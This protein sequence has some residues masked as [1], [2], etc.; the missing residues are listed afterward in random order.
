M[1]NLPIAVFG[2]LLILTLLF[3]DSPVAITSPKTGESLRGLIEIRG[4]MDSQNFSSAELSFTFDAAAS[5]PAAG[6]FTI[7]TFSQPMANPALAEWDTTAVTDGDYTL[8]LR[9]SLQDG[10]FQDAL[11]TG[12]KIHNDEPPPIVTAPPTLA[13]F[14]FQPLDNSPSPNELTPTPVVIYPTSTLLP[15][16]PASL[17]ASSI[18]TIF[19]Q[20][21]LVVLIL[22]AFFSLILRLRKNI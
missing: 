12:L 16:N 1:L 3:Q 20:S 11:I 19:W 15:S 6:W 9:V 5:D 10:S 13:D 21:A 8:R 2:F 14:N 4:R 18:F 17:S 7:Q 22:F